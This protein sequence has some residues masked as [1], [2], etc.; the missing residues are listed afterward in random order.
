MFVDRGQFELPDPD[1]FWFID[2]ELLIKIWRAEVNAI[3]LLC[4][5]YPNFPELFDAP[6]ASIPQRTACFRLLTRR[7]CLDMLE[8][9][10]ASRINEPFPLSNEDAS[11]LGCSQNLVAPDAPAWA[12]EI[13]EISDL[14]PFRIVESLPE[15]LRR[16]GFNRK[17][18][19][20]NEAL[21]LA[22][23]ALST[24]EQVQAVTD[25]VFNEQ[26]R[27]LKKRWLAPVAQAKKPNERK[28][29]EQRLKL[30]GAIRKILTASPGLQ[31][32]PFC[33]ELDKRHALP[34]YDWIKSGEWPDGLTWKEA[35][36]N[37]TLRRRIR[38]V[39]QEAMRSR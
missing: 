34:L 31:G 36:R 39:R 21:R 28:G 35:W 29:W 6:D 16:E 2:T 30:Y 14:L 10:N 5:K 25:R 7:K 11:A 4:A 3:T 17:D 26:L 15:P 20:E 8:E 24:I 12:R 9:S 13:K 23:A 19:A 27:R 22:V 1:P 18:D 32:I 38:R 33:A 37:P